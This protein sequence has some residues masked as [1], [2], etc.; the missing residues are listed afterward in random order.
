MTGAE[1]ALLVGVGSKLLGGLFGESPQEAREKFIRSMLAKAEKGYE[2]GLKS[3]GS[4]YARMRILSDVDRR[5]E[6][7]RALTAGASERTRQTLNRRLGNAGAIVAEAVAGNQEQTGNVEA[8]KFLVGNLAGF[9]Q[10]A[11]AQALQE[12]EQRKAMYL[13]AIYGQPIQGPGNNRAGRVADAVISGT[14]DIMDYYGRFNGAGGGD[15]TSGVDTNM[16]TPDNPHEYNPDPR[17]S[18]A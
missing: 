7:L 8:S 11:S 5:T 6:A 15:T 10:A 17:G 13:A 18:F 14:A 9:E 1:V 12:A 4:R 2:R 16:F 3:R